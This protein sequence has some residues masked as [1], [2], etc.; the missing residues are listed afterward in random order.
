[1]QPR[2]PLK[3]TLPPKGP[4]EKRGGVPREKFPGFFKRGPLSI[5][6]SRQ[7]S[8]SQ[9]KTLAE[10]LLKERFPRQT[11][12]AD[13]QGWEIQREV[14]RLKNALPR[15]KTGAEQNTIRQAIAR[16][17]EAKKRAGL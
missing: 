3:P 16:L 10:K 7:M 6:W 4:W 8:S 13:I 14:K 12:G 15:A 9:Q 5:P 2:K 17:E 11:Y 1:M